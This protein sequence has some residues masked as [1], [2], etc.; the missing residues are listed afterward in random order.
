MNIDPNTVAL[1]T[2][3]ASGLG[4]A[5]IRALVS[6]GAKAVIVDLNAERGQALAE[7]L[8]DGVVFSADGDLKLAAPRRPP[9]SWAICASPSAV[10]ASARRPRPSAAAAR[11][12]STCTAR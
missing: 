6:A 8:G 4:E 2:G 1:V 5:T 9:R 12:I 11:T 10:P 7:E 3:G